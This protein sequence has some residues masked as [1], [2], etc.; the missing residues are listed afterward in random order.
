MINGASASKEIP[1]LLRDMHFCIAFTKPILNH[2]NLVFATTPCLL[3]YMWFLI[4]ICSIIFFSIHI[5]LSKFCL[6]FS[7]PK[8]AIFPLR[9]F[10]QLVVSCKKNNW[11]LCQVISPVFVIFSFSDQSIYT[12]HIFPKIRNHYNS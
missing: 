6:Y 10:F 5:L 12:L 9:L 2:I 3:L 7:F 1:E 11:A 8:L 4:H